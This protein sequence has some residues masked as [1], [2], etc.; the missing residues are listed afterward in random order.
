MRQFRTVFKFE[1]L[2]YVRSKSYIVMTAILLL[3]VILG[4]SFPTIAGLASGMFGGR[5]GIFDGIAG[6]GGGGRDGEGEG[7]GDAGGDG[8]GEV[9]KAALLDAGGSLSDELLESYLPAFEWERVG[10]LDGVEGRIE[11]GEL[12]MALAVDGLDFTLYEMQESIAAASSSSWTPASEMVLA[13]YRGEALAAAG[14]SQPE[15][16]AILGAA[17]SGERVTVGKDFMQNYWIAYALVF[18]LYITTIM[19]G[20][21]TL[22]SVVTEK[23]SK[24]MELLITSAKPLR[25]MFG[26]VFGTGCAGL[27]Q[28]CA[29]MLC[30]AASLGANMRSWER[31]SPEIAGIIS[32]TFSAGIMVYAVAFFLLGFF[33]YAFIY[34]AMG[35][36]VSR[37]EDAGAV[38]TLPMILV[39]AT[40]MVSMA[41]M[42]MPSAPYV[43]VCS[44]VPFLSPMVMF[45]RV[46]MTEVPLYEVLAAIAL[47][48]AYVFCSGWVSAKIYRVGVMLYGNAPKPRDILRYIRQA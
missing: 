8:S 37:M 48:C 17:A 36:T 23:S 38:A 1:Y 33:S 20:Q 47:N 46:C 29:V 18:L 24:A 21:Y 15:I 13:A 31:L 12:S 41:G 5:G 14:L 44:F 39:V 45:V 7:E 10:S 3:V 27:T 26:K 40:F 30:A 11:G 2:N 34:A 25:L 42:A 6:G 16:G 43:T 19:Y 32:A 4:G 9:K 35:S 28:F 22:V